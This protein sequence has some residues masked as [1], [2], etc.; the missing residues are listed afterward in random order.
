MLLT[1]PNVVGAGLTAPRATDCQPIASPDASPDACPVAPAGGT[2][3]LPR[4]RPR[5]SG[6]FLF[7]GD[8]KLY[9]RGTTYG[10]FC[11]T[12]DGTETYHR[13]AVERD[14]AAIAAHG[15]NAVRTYTLPPRWLLDAAERHGLRVMVGMWWGQNTAF[16]DEPG[17]ADAIVREVREGVRACAG[18]PA[19]LCYA[20]ANEIPALIARWLGHRRVEQFLERLYHAV[21]AE[22]P[23]GL[24]TYV[25]YPSTEY[26]R[27]P[28]LDLVCFNVYLESQPKL[29]SYLARL[30]N[31]A[32]DRPLLMG[33]I[34]LDSRGHGEDTQASILDWQV[35]TAF[36][37]GCAGA[38]VFAWTDEWH[39]GGQD[40][41][42]WDFGLTR[43]D[44]TPKPA[45]EAVS[46]AFGDLPLPRATSLPRISVVVC[47]YNGHRT[48]RQCLQALGRLEYPDYE[49]IVVDDGSSS[50]ESARIAGEYDVRLIRT[51][52][53]GLSSARNTG[54]EAATGEIVAYVDDDAFPDPHWLTYLAQAFLKSPVV[55][56]GG[57]NI[58]LPD[59]GATADCVANA[60]GGPIHVLLSDDEAEHI[61]GCNS[62]FRKAAL[63]AIGGFDPQFHVAGD[64]VDV[65]WRL[66]ERGWTLGF[67]PAAVVWHHRRNT[68]R[69]YW[70]QQ[71]G[72]GRAEA[73]LERKWPEKYNS[74]GHLA[75]AGRIYASYLTQMISL[76]STRIYHGTWGS[77]LFQSLYQPAPS[78][79]RALVMM[80]EWYLVLLG[81]AVLACLGALWRPLLLDVPLLAI[82]LGALV[83][84]A[85]LSAVSS[86][87]PSAPRSRGERLKRYGLTA[88]LHLLQPLARLAGRLREGLTPWRRRVRGI[89]LPT[90]RTAT[91]W[92][93]QWKAFDARLHAIEAALLAQRAATRRGGEYDRWDLEVRGGTLG[94][95]RTLMTVEEHG[96]GRQF[97]R[98][99]SWPRCSGGALV[100]VA[101]LGTLAAGA[102]A[103]AAWGV[104]AVLASAAGL[105]ALRALYEC[106]SAMSA[107][108][109]ALGEVGITAGADRDR[110]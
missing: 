12:A 6:K 46:R 86:P 48:I 1:H 66:R 4:P 20:I 9:V 59:D 104:S 27:L 67:S 65:C 19:V 68:V 44:R 87:F 43:R 77:A 96:Q 70:R 89:V 72:Y 108:V 34:G 22:D 24:V 39:C 81:A 40:I 51:E 71:R 83:A 105:V 37:S 29:E 26:L 100:S 3:A 33:E 76:R 30:H 5:A 23:E 88:L 10:T 110:R 38:F 78:A 61:P 18:H 63:E 79:M 64:D 32:G 50:D 31:L 102:A 106:G 107:V 54:L 80:P 53:R 82:L 21:K 15:M 17:R 98:V 7:A 8:T 14:F 99:R 94:I 2:V 57:P 69:A 55:G 74:M 16:L 11:P 101:A 42:D 45:L 35:R 36:A 90:P 47:T 84:H 103:D 28:F 56:V 13:D 60:P 93:E 73:M 109:R 75:W 91:H 41:V 58:P 95:V 62:A 85:T 92:G 52:N 25:N 97:T 49:V